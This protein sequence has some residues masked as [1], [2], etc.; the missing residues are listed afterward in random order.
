[1]KVSKRALRFV[2]KKDWKEQFVEGLEKTKDLT[3]L[4]KKVL[5]EQLGVI[6]QLGKSGL[7]YVPPKKVRLD[8]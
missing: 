1:M 2:K 7:V 4:Q 3:D 8:F 5:M 6:E